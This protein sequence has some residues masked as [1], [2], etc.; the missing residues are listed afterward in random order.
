M[1]YVVKVAIV[2]FGQVQSKPLETLPIGASSLELL[3]YTYFW[4]S[5]LIL[6][7]YF[8]VFIS[9]GIYIQ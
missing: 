2:N 5:T 9:N 4:L 3:E 6:D 7:A 1:L 8:L